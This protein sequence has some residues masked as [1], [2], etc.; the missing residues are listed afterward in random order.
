MRLFRRTPPTEDRD[1]KPI[2]SIPIYA[3]QVPVDTSPVLDVD[4]FNALRVGDAWACVRVL[5][6]SIA[7]LPVK[8]YRDTGQGRVPVP[9]GRLSRLLAHPSPGS[10]SADLFSSIM[11]HLQVNGNCYLGKWRDSSGEIVALSPLPPSAVTVVLKGM[12]IGYWVWLPDQDQTLFG[13]SDILH[14]KGLSGVSTTYGG[15]LVGLSPVTMARLTL[16]LS[17]NLQESSQAYFLNG[18][19]PSGILSVQVAQSD[20][21]MEAIRERWDT[22][23]AGTENMSRVAVLSGQATFTPVSFS[24]DDSQFLQQRE[25]SAREVARVFRIPG[26]MIDAIPQHASHMYSNVNQANLNYV[27][28]SLRPWLVR[29]ERAFS[30]DSDLC[31][32]GSYLSFDLDGLLRGDPDLRTTIY[33]RA[34][35]TTGAGVAPG[36]MTVEE[37]R[38]AEDLPPMQHAEPGQA[39]AMVEVPSTN[40]ASA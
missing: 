6:D 10:T 26:W 37:I 33:Q 16:T 35:G 13:E 34:L 17:S 14:I 38:E 30:A 8:V 5:C 23:H 3:S 15:D 11:C 18:S 21:T 24:A 19:R 4:Q 31:P 27:Q 40:G 39:S 12:E 36:W 2:T 22:R 32:G 20:A 9:D 1:L 28:H 29:I 7:S 25:L